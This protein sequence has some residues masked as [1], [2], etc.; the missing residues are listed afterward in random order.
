MP[1][2][3]IARPDP[4]AEGTAT[5]SEEREGRGKGRRTATDEDRRRAPA[6]WFRMGEAIT[7]DHRPVAVTPRTRYLD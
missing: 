1:G 5:G 6:A 7:L 3:G 4:A 2:E